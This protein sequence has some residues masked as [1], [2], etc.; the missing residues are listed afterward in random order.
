MVYGMM[1]KKITKYLGL[2]A[3][4][5]SLSLTGCENES[6]KT[7]IKFST[8]GSETEINIIKPLIKDFEKQ[9]PDIKVDLMHIP[10]NYFQKLHMLVAANLTPDVIFINNLNIPVYA[11]G[12]ILTDLNQKLNEDPK[13]KKDAFFEK[14]LKTMNYKSELLAIPR[15]IS[16]IVIYYNKDLFDQY[17]MAY[18]SEDWTLDDYLT[19]AKKLT[20]TSAN[21][22]D[23][24]GTSFATH[25]IFFLPF[26]WSNKGK[27]FNNN[28]EEF[29]LSEEDACNSLQFY[30]D[31]RNKYHVAP[32]AAESGNNTMAELF[33]QGRL[34]MFISGRWSVPRFREDLK[35]NWD[36]AKFPAGQAGSIVGADGSGWAMYSKTKHPK[37]A[38]KLIQFLASESSIKQFTETGLI[39]PSRKDVANSE[40]FYKKNTKPEN[41]RIF[42]SIIDNARPTPKVKRWNEIIDTIN[43]TLEPAWNGN[44]TTCKALQKITPEINELLE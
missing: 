32:T 42:L 13:L 29:S 31:L 2:T 27:L 16:N 40:S 11:S 39:V 17:K 14:S 35:F 10:Q 22:Q 41:A 19:T 36:I 15:D 6:S 12:K 20:P 38:W 18:P 7:T 25:P 43:T 24:F 44:T 34:A 1:L 5:I 3:L 8:W 33:M 37:E 30:A 23:H 4:I 9:N 21:R 28:N 26:V